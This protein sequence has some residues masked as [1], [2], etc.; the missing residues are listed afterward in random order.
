MKAHARF[1]KPGARVEHSRIRPTGPPGPTGR[2]AR[3][4]P[5]M[6]HLPHPER[7]NQAGVTP[8]IDLRDQARLGGPHHDSVD[9]G[10]EG[11]GCR[12]ACMSAG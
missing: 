11:S 4:C 6:R 5:T 9:E 10:P 7:G 2:C 12:R 8:V 3:R 1:R